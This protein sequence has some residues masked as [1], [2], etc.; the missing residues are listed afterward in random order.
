MADALA[1]RLIHQFVP[2]F[3]LMPEGIK[4][5]E[6]MAAS[7]G[8]RA[9][10]AYT[11]AFRAHVGP[12]T[13]PSPNALPTGL[14]GGLDDTTRK[15]GLLNGAMGGLGITMAAVFGT[16][17]VLHQMKQMA[18]AAEE[19]SDKVDQ[20]RIVFGSSGDAMLQWADTSVEAMGLSK[21]EALETSNIMGNL[22]VEANLGMA[23]SAEMTQGIMQRSA[24]LA[25]SFGG[26]QEEAAKAIQSALFGK[27]TALRNQYGVLMN[28]VTIGEKARAMGLWEEGTA[29]SNAARAEAAYA[30]AMEATAKVEGEYARQ[31][32][33]PSAK[34]NEAAKAI[35]NL[36]A[37]MGEDLLPVYAE[38]MQ[39]GANVA[40]WIS[41]HEALVLTIVKVA[42]ALAALALAWKAV[43]A[44][45]AFA[46]N[47]QIA[48]ALAG[49]TGGAGAKGLAGMAGRIL[50]PLALAAIGGD[51]VSN[52]DVMSRRAA[53]AGGPLAYAGASAQ[54][55]TSAAA[56]ILDIP[57]GMLGL[58]SMREGWDN[59]TGITA[60]RDQI[61]AEEKLQEVNEWGEQALKNYSAAQAEKEAATKGG[62]IATEEQIEAQK[63]YYET[64]KTGAQGILS[65]L[66][67]YGTP[68]SQDKIEKADTKLESA[69]ENV[70][71][72]RRNLEKIRRDYAEGG[73][74]V[75][76]AQKDYADALA[77]QEEAQDAARVARHGL[78]REELD[79]NRKAN[80][81]IFEQQAEDY[82]KVASSGLNGMAQL[83]MFQLDPETLHS[84]ASG[85]MDKKWVDATN[86]SF[87]KA[88][89]IAESM[90]IM[91]EAAQKQVDQAWETM[92]QKNMEA[93]NRT[94]AGSTITVPVPHGAAAAGT[95]PSIVGTH[96]SFNVNTVNPVT[97]DNIDRSAKPWVSVGSVTV[98]SS[99][100]IDF[101][102]KLGA[103]ARRDALEGRTR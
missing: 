49:L 93:Y 44:A 25:A 51:M 92:A 66:D 70:D 58:P 5:A 54:G 87:N 102:N 18:D 10:E 40:K 2:D 1:G 32:D 43:G 42:G 8:A 39:T 98:V 15:T 60:T 64:I 71:A 82:E 78:S 37:K 33:D 34:A 21:R 30:I 24:D 19:L 13:V 46:K 59:L 91:V 35:E 69:N 62:T 9:A 67:I 99:D 48:A 17:L 94:L 7:G 103:M 4:A 45:A 84:I 83:A 52:W 20:T 23:R 6:L 73:Q 74:H 77:A 79:K 55:F 41:D 22:F 57:G 53:D 56:G 14:P 97:G 68:E 89:K 38:L 101:T 100:P 36:S 96:G 11:A 3:S 76:D 27:T 80:M 65:N 47:E 26:T 29:L 90:Q 61:A 72:A 75:L 88:N 85:P 12:L 86:A 50:P 28:S 81:A 31:S 63:K 95:G 16:G